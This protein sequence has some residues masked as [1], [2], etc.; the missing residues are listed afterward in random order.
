M[1]NYCIKRDIGLALGTLPA[2]GRLIVLLEFRDARIAEGVITWPHSESN[3][4]KK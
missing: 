4:T 3:G 1:H 2:L